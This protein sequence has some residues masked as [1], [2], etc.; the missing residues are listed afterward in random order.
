MPVDDAKLSSSSDPEQ[1]RFADY[2]LDVSLGTLL[3]DGD[4]IDLRP[5]SYEVL[6]FLVRHPRR[7]VSRDEISDSVWG[8]AIA[9]DNSVDQC[10]HEIRR[11]FGDDG[12]ALVKTVPRRG[13]IFDVDVTPAAKSAP[14]EIV[15]WHRRHK[16]SRLAAI[17][18]AV[19]LA[20]IALRESTLFDFGTGEAQDVTVL[21]VTAAMLADAFAEET[22]L[23]TGELSM[24][25]TASISFEQGLIHLRR[26]ENGGG[27]SAGRQAIQYFQ[28]SVE[29]DPAWAPSRAALSRALHWLAS[30]GIGDDTEST[31]EAARRQAWE[32]IALDPT[33]GPAY[34]AVA[35]I[36]MAHDRDF[37]SA[38]RNYRLAAANG[39]PS[40]WGRGLYYRWT[41]QIENA[42]SQYRNALQLYPQARH[43]RWELAS[44]LL[45]A[46]RFKE[47]ERYFWSIASIEE[48]APIY[49]P[50]AYMAAKSGHAAEAQKLLAVLVNDQVRQPVPAVYAL[51][52]Q[53]EL[54]EAK[55]A[56]LEA[57]DRWHP[58]DHLRTTQ[59]LGEPLRSLDYLEAAARADP[60]ALQWVQCPEA[61]GS[62]AD[63]PRYQKLIRTSAYYPAGMS[64]ASN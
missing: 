30:T 15:G 35:F 52:G 3:K 62:L 1:Y 31:Y 38:D 43:L 61:L 40:H 32:S 21:P 59:A 2:C 64:G 8:R 49:G 13:I 46:G 22:A 5:K 11:A 63:H 33:H 36:N 23:H 29:A 45:C 9:S 20:A 42:I 4:R 58:L 14:G 24:N 6:A 25:E 53:V 10:I 44:T 37:E 12:R 47:A 41:G 19:A 28:E 17:V 57:E 39:F 48:R 56:A 55:L 50:L 7:L 16:I 26:L 60:D 34:A 18:A 54:A 27:R 51:L